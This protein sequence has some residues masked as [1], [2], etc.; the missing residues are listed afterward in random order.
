MP[1]PFSSTR[2]TAWEWTQAVVLA[3]N[4]A[5]TTLCLGGYRSDTMVVTAGLNGLLLLV[6]L[7]ARFAGKTGRVHPAGI[8]L[9]PFLAYAAVNVLGVTPVRWHGWQDWLEWAQMI[10]VFWVVLNGVRAPAARSFLFTVIIGLGAVAVALACYQRFVQP[11]WL[12]LGRIQADQFIGRASGPFGIPNSLAAFLLLLLPAAVRQAGRRD[13]G[14]IPRILY[15]GAAAFFAVGLVLTISRGAW[16]GLALALAVWP[17]FAGRRR[18]FW[19][20]GGTVAVLGAVLAVGAA[21]Y[22]AVPQ[23]KERLDALVRD[24]GERTR[25]IMWKGAWQIFQQH[26]AFGGGAGAYNVLFEQFRPERYQD[27]PQWAHNDYL[28]T[29][30]DYGVTGFILFFG[31]CAFIAWRSVR[32]SE[33]VMGPPS[34]SFDH[35][36]VTR[37]LVVGMLAF[38]L[39]LFVDFHLK[40]PALAMILAAL[41]AL[42]VQHRWTCPSEAGS[43]SRVSRCF[44]ATF[45]IMIVS[46]TVGFVLPHYRGEAIRSDARREID[47]LARHPVAPEAER[48]VI[49]H[50]RAELNRAADIDPRNS[51]TWADWAYATALWSRHETDKESEF[52]REAE[53][54]ARRALALSNVVPEFW[55]RL[56]VSLD[57]QRRW[58]DAGEAFTQALGLA[59]ASAPM[60]YYQAYHLALKPAGR[61]PAQGAVAICL[62]L[63]PGNREAE[64][65]R[66]RLAESR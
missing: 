40:I 17:L 22:F 10:A 55:L 47:Q 39:Q 33:P 45:M 52:G 12:M 37:G 6:H 57:M 50:A 21:L 18:W 61:G 59:P 5:W 1:S 43:P 36:L 53:I 65:L 60:W 32:G 38:W 13:A 20:L 11:D 2:A 51:Q 64:A 14:A 23:V 46:A 56:G 7:A 4:L 28:N 48:G 42:I 54:Y 15:G 66:Q 8:F 16:L 63:D 35:R 26:P 31:A 29:L 27:A 49:L 34:S 25:P 58:V 30:S 44:D 19:R 3:V 62:R 9:L 24:S 41:S